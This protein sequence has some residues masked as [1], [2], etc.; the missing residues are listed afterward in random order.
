MKQ[1]EIPHL[2]TADKP[3]TPGG[4][5][6]LSEVII[7]Y[8]HELLPLINKKHNWGFVCKNML[9]FATAGA[10]KSPKWNVQYVVRGRCGT[11]LYR[12]LIFAFLSTSLKRLCLIQLFPMIHENIWAST[13]E[14]LSMGFCEQQSADQPAHPRSL[15]STFVI[16][17][18][19]S[20]LSRLAMSVFSI[21]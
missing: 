15:I 4:L 12:F 2:Q 7:P 11:W 16:R 10:E 1:W 3:S 17:L 6:R 13:W 20:I 18:L 19:E 9:V 21:F 14:N 8:F 5:K